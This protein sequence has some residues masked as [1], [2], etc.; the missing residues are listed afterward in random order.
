MAGDVGPPLKKIYRKYIARHIAASNEN[1]FK[2][3]LYT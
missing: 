3:T 2:N 1:H